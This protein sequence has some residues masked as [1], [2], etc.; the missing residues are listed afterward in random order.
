MTRKEIVDKELTQVKNL[1][2]KQIEAL[3]NY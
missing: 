1:A 3:E 2:K